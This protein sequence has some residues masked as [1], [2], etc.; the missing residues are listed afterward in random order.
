MSLY[1]PHRGSLSAFI[2]LVKRVE[3]IDELCQVIKTE[4]Q[5]Y[6]PAFVDAST[7]HI[8]HYGHDARIN[9]NTYIVTLTG[10]GV[11]GFTDSDFK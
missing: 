1:R 8:Q 3:T 7:V 5:D 6:S 2:D 4:L 11:V 10:Y 9:W